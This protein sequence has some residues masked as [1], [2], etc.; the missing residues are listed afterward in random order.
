MRKK[1]VC[2]LFYFYTILF[3]KC[4]IARAV[5]KCIKWAKAEHA[6][7][8][9]TTFVAGV[10]FAFM[11]FKIAKI[12]FHCLPSLMLYTRPLYPKKILQIQ[13]MSYSKDEEIQPRHFFALLCKGFLFAQKVFPK[14]IYNLSQILQVE[15]SIFHSKIVKIIIMI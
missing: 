11:V 8:V 6:V 10:I 9:I 4:R 13:D 3:N 2:T 15:N 5:C 1:T 12:I 7:Y 14:K